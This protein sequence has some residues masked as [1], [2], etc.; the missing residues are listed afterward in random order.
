MMTCDGSPN[1]PGTVTYRTDD[2]PD[3]VACTGCVAC[4]PWTAED[5]ELNEPLPG[6]MKP[7]PAVLEA[8]KGLQWLSEHPEYR[9]SPEE[10]I[11]RSTRFGEGC[12]HPVADHTQSSSPNEDCDCC[13]GR[14]NE[15]KT[16]PDSKF[17]AQA[18]LYADMFRTLAETISGPSRTLPNRR[19][20]RGTRGKSGKRR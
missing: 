17:D 10:V 16:S 6:Y 11:C 15:P 20:R 5:Y 13:T 2:G 9:R 7:T 3:H 8:A 19:D 4:K 1:N 12:G 18:S 14:Q